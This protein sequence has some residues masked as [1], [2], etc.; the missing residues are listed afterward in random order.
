MEMNKGDKR[1]RIIYSAINGLLG[2]GVFISGFCIYAALVFQ[3][4][5]ARRY[6]YIFVGA[7]ILLIVFLVIQGVQA[8]NKVRTKQFSVGDI[9]KESLIMLG[10]SILWVIPS[11]LFW[12]W[13]D[14]CL[15]G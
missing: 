4:V 9:V 15:L 5:I 11:W 2:S 1:K 8:V 6:K 3:E 12:A 14:F 13:V 7:G 10:L